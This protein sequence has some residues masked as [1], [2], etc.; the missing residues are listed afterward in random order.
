LADIGCAATPV[1]TISA[2]AALKVS[3]TTSPVVMTLLATL[4]PED[5]HG[6]IVVAFVPDEEIGLRGANPWP[7]SDARRRR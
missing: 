2:P 7:T 4:A 6:D 3:I 5:A 1:N